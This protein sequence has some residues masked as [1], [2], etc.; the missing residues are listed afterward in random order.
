MLVVPNILC[1]VLWLWT[2]YIVSLILGSLI[3]STLRPMILRLVLV[4]SRYRMPL[5]HLELLAIMVCTRCFVCRLGFIGSRVV[6][7]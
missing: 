6:L 1:I 3:G 7:L 2:L 4:S 5:K